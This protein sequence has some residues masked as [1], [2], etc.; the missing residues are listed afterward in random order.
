MGKIVNNKL[1][2]AYGDDFLSGRKGKKGRVS[3]FAIIEGQKEI[4]TEDD[5]DQYISI[6][7]DIVKE[8]GIWK[9]CVQCGTISED[10]PECNCERKKGGILVLKEIKPS[11]DDDEL[12]KCYVCKVVNPKRNIVRQFVFLKDAPASVIATSLYQNLDKNK[13]G[14]RKILIFSDSRQDAAFFAPYLEHTYKRILFKHLI[15]RAIMENKNIVDY[16]LNSLCSDL[17]KLAEQYDIFSKK[18]DYKEKIKE[19]WNWILLE[20]FNMWDRNTSLEGVGLITFKPIFP[21]NWQPL[22]ELQRPPWNLTEE[23]TKNLY[24]MML[25]TMRYN[26]AVKFPDKAEGPRKN[27]FF[28]PKNKEYKFKFSES[29]RKKGIIGFKPS[30]RYL[31]TRLEFLEKLYQSL[32]GIKICRDECLEILKKLW[33]DL[34]DNWVDNGIYHIYDKKDGILYQLDYAYWR[35]YSEYNHKTWY[36]CNSCG[37]IYPFSI[38]G[39]CPTYNC[40]GR[41]SLIGERERENLE[42]NHYRYLYK[43]IKPLNLKA[44]EHTAQLRTDKASE[45]QGQFSRGKVNV[46]SCSTTFEMGV[47]LGELEVIFLKNVP[48]EPS[49]YVQR[50]GRAGRR[51]NVA[52]LTLTFA[53]LRSHDLTYFNNPEDMV[54]GR[55]KPPI[56]ELRNEKI[57]QRHLNSIVLSYFFKAF[58]D[59]YGSLNDFFKF[60][61]A[62]IDAVQKLEGF[63]SYRPHSIYKSLKRVIPEDIQEKFDIENWGWISNLIGENGLLTVTYNKVKDEMDKLR[64]FYERRNKEYSQLDSLKLKASCDRDIKWALKRIE[65]IKK[66]GL[67]NFLASNVIIPK[68]GFPVDVVELDIK[69]HLDKA[70]DIEL[71]RDLRIGIS[72]FAP[73]SKVVANGY[74]WESN[75]IKVVKDKALDEYWYVECPKCHKFHIEKVTGKEH[76]IN[77]CQVCNYSF[78]KQEIDRF[79]IPRFGFISSKDTEPKRVAEYRPRK[80]YS[81][82]PYFYNYSS[83]EEKILKYNGWKIVCNYS[84]DGELAVI[85]KGKRG[86]GFWICSKCG[87]AFSGK[88]SS[89]HKTPYGNECKG[90]L[91]PHLHLGHTFRTDVLTILFPK[92]LTREFERNSFWYSLLYALLEGAS[93]AIGINRRDIDGCLYP[94]S[95]GKM[96]VLFDNVPGGAGLVKQLFDEEVFQLML[97][98]AYKRTASCSCGPETSCYSCLR[99]YQNQFCHHILRRGIVS[100]FL[101][102]LI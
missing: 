10:E 90:K 21:D 53:L 66:A 27:S 56:V 51:A 72:E 41:L 4:E 19:A 2:F 89:P 24:W 101:S 83:P 31:N 61:Q 26:M 35:I 75:G 52:G 7:R 80:E 57:I 37:N 25:N 91:K 85:C 34:T 60:E 86:A 48:P 11:G 8:G 29:D 88:K 100:E 32:T 84:S 59:Y 22:E 98:L 94:T 6:D 50:A 99:N 46:L 43:N 69:S 87:A 14:D 64:D 95:K 12:H 30:T 62:E 68:Y 96:L 102:K 15:Y 45:I 77:R 20:F 74:I 55:I 3:Y 9:L 67:I 82:R 33:D 36:V 1:V 71:E 70:K 5:E 54:N 23:E 42:R 18:M 79:I 17:V 76:S 97:E 47:D 92:E 28:E 39:I 49:N 40:Y 13:P 63:L 73:G 58:P 44:K 93:Q 16:R 38:K 65:T 78:S 81:T